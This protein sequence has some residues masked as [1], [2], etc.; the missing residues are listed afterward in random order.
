VWAIPLAEPASAFPVVA[1]PAYRTGGQFSPDGRWVAYNSRETGRAEVYITSFPGKGARWQVSASG[2][3]QPRWR[4]DGKELFFI[5]GAGE[6]MAAAIEAQGD[7]LEIRDVKPLF[8]VNLF[9]GPRLGAHGYDV[10]PD[11]KRF[12]ANSAGEAGGARIAI[13]S[14]WDAGLLRQ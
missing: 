2:G 10:S 12:L 6:L 5:S 9:T 4:R 8:R 7:Q 3:T 13:V 14:N 1:S 11:G